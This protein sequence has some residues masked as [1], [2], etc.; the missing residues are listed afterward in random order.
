MNA[1]GTIKVLYKSI[2]SKGTYNFPVSPMTG[3]QTYLRSGFFYL[4]LDT[5]SETAFKNVADPIYPVSI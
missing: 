1:F 5:T 4:I 3:S 2:N